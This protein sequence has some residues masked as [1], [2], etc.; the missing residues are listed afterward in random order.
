MPRGDRDAHADKPK[1]KA[2]S[3]THRFRS[4]NMYSTQAQRAEV[5]FRRRAGGGVGAG[6]ARCLRHA[7]QN[8]G[9][10]GRRSRPVHCR[11]G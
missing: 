11:F 6:P 3:D 10:G 4:A 9:S 7:T 8:R 5:G 2:A 1:R